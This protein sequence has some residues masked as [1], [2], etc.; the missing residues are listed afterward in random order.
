MIFL[1]SRSFVHLN[2]FL[3]VLDRIPLDLNFIVHLLAYFDFRL[4]V[5]HL[6]LHLCELVGLLL[7]FLA[8]SFK[9]HQVVE[10]EFQR[11]LVIQIGD[12]V[13]DFVEK[14]V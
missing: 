3:Q 7:T 8:A 6:T 5:L 12:C 11:L 9:A 13:V 14:L 1:S 10:E 2:L 4:E